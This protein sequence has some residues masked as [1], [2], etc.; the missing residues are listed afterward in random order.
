MSDQRKE[1]DKERRGKEGRENT[2]K[3]DNGKFWDD[4][5]NIR[6]SPSIIVACRDRI[7]SLLESQR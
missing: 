6:P 4:A 7:P 1:D 3:K 2:R 5:M